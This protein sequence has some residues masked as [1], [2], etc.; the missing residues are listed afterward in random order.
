MKEKRPPKHLSKE[1][2]KLWRSICS[3]WDFDASGFMLLQTAFEA[4]DRLLEAKNIIDR[5][6]I[7]IE[8]PTK[9]KKIHP[10]LRIE[11]ESRAGFLQAWR[12]LNLDIDAPGDIG[13][14]PG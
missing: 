9:F 1:S 5:D 7:V 13:R 8:T 4:Y 11:K 3:Q 12:M 10:A 14:P 2:K 6:G